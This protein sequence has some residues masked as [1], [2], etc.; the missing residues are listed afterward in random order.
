MPFFFF[1]SCP[2]TSCCFLVITL[3]SLSIL[4]SSANI[5]LHPAQ[6]Q[7]PQLLHFSLKHTKT[8]N[9]L[10]PLLLPLSP[11]FLISSLL[12]SSLTDMI[13]SCFQ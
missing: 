13:H 11:V 2:F 10:I 4:S 12:V 7:C 1:F 8:S 5:L 9:C 6:L 3:P